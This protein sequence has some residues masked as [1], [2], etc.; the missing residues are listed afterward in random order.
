M[1]PDHVSRY[2]IAYTT[3]YLYG[4]TSLL[5]L[6][7]YTKWKTSKWKLLNWFNTEQVVTHSPI[8]VDDDEW[9]CRARH[10]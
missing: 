7:T 8:Y 2:H 6:R 4:E 5:R 10:K 1:R 9:I 3:A